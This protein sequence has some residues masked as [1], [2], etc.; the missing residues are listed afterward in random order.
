[1]GTLHVAKRTS[2]ETPGR[3]LASWTRAL[4]RASSTRGSAR[5]GL[6]NGAVDRTPLSSFKHKP[7]HV[8]KDWS[9][10]TWGSLQDIRRM[11]EEV[12]AVQ[13][14][15]GGGGG[16][17][18]GAGGGAGGG[19]GGGGVYGAEEQASDVR[20]RFR[21]AA[22]EER[23]RQAGEEVPEQQGAGREPCACTGSTCGGMEKML[24]ELM[25]RLDEQARELREIKASLAQRP[26]ETRT[27]TETERQRETQAQT[28]T[29]TDRHRD[30]ETTASVGQ[31]PAPRP[32]SEVGV[33]VR[34]CG[35]GVED[36]CCHNSHHAHTDAACCD[37][38]GHGWCQREDA[39]EAVSGAEDAEEAVS[40]A[41]QVDDLQVFD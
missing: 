27:E 39:E 34:A 16:G 17:G 32:T 24:A 10:A 23:R 31:R 36:G 15:G 14:S 21:E 41:V 9:N 40:G 4:W 30:R 1:M 29:R 18:S 7:L 35:S 2:E 11:E 8:P 20:Q 12:A 25:R 37:S 19:G 38:G 5:G 33:F 26:A 28:Q 6:L 22:S 3:A 13:S